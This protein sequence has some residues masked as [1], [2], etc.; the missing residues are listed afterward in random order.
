L[1]GGIDIAIGGMRAPHP[2]ASP[3]R[4][5][6]GGGGGAIDQ[7]TDLLEG[8]VEHVVQHEG[9]PLGW[10]QPVQHHQQREADRV[11]EDGLVGR[12]GHVAA[13]DRIGDVHA[14]R[15]LRPRC[16]RAQPVEADPGDDR[17]Q[18]A[19]GIVHVILPRAADPHPRVLKRV[20]GLGRRSEHPVAQAVQAG[21]VL[22]ELPGQP[23]IRVHPSHPSRARCHQPVVTRRATPL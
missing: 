1:S 9:E 6:A 5:L 16:A 2:S 7:G 14:R 19:A 11:G 15:V 13:D 21:P 20:V 8:Q 23:V 3:A 22:L 12:G 17:R 18:P 4:E 10:G